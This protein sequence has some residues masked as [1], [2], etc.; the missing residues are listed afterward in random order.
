MADKL[1]PFDPTA[2]LQQRAARK[3]KMAEVLLKLGLQQQNYV[4]PMQ[5]VGQLAQAWAGNMMDKSAEKDNSAI[6]KVLKDQTNQDLTTV[7]APNVT[8]PEIAAAMTRSGDYLP[9]YVTDPLKSARSERMNWEA[10]M[11]PVVHGNI[12]YDQRKMVPGQVVAGDPNSLVQRLPSGDLAINPTA[13][14]ANLYQNAARGG[15]LDE[16]MLTPGPGGVPTVTI[17][18]SPDPFQAPA[19]QDYGA[20]P[21]PATDEEAYLR[22]HMNDPRIREIA[23]QKY[24]DWYNL[25]FGDQ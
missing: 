10:R 14:A 16:S 11:R 9:D 23:K 19:R 12:V 22:Q 3:R 20:P 24:P 25:E 8:E 2:D 18:N 13:F 15:G 1:N 6:L 17:P 4:H 7:M 21:K 5:V